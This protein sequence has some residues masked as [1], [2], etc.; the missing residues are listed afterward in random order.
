M[1]HLEGT[2]RY[3]T[4]IMSLDEMVDTEH[5]V[6]II[7][8]FIEVVDLT[9]LGFK[10]TTPA[11][12]GRPSYS[13]AHLAKLYLFGYE[14][15]VR[16]SR[17]LERLCHE[18][19]PALWLLDGLAPDF[20]TIADFRKDNTGALGALFYE[21]A[22]FLDS[23]GLYGKRLAAID[24]TKIKA[25]NSRKS[26][27]T[28][29]KLAKHIA[30][31]TEKMQAYLGELEAADDEETCTRAQ[32]G[33]THCTERL[34][35][36]EG[37]QERLDEV[38]DT[39]L[40][41]V[42]PDARLMVS[43]SGVEMAYNVQAVVDAKHH[44]VADFATTTNPTD[45]GQLAHMAQATQETMRKRDIR[46]VADKGYYSG[47]DLKACEDG[48][49][50]V[51]VARQN[52]PGEASAQKGA[53]SADKFSYDAQTDSYTCPAG[54]LLTCRSKPTS[55]LK[56]Y[57]NKRACKTCPDRSACLSKNS[58]YRYLRR[59]GNTAVLDR[60]A[61]KYADNTADYRL[62][63]QIVEHVFG[64]IKRTMGGGY[65]LVRTQER[66]NAESALL[67][68]CYNMK[69]TK[70]VLG[71]AHMMELLDSYG[72]RFGAHK[73]LCGV[74]AAWTCLISLLNAFHSDNQPYSYRQRDNSP[75]VPTTW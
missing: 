59:D 1:T 49:I 71:F 10:N 64:T 39:Q 16:S 70:A 2:D 43:K 38:E 73:G 65:F 45:H 30:Y 5:I 22:S 75:L 25:S 58:S 23:A 46:F 17:K 33:I 60:A 72:D 32:E 4:R 68:L 34:A 44:L 19:I 63:Q 40:S 51:V 24:G 41:L 7:D 62:R 66:V 26:N 52:K 28:K 3:Q 6:R 11:A 69:R 50:D 56:R 74:C 20:K 37:Y 53:Y 55:K 42:D 21:F 54:N 36:L 12:M 31:H 48:G 29:K 47:A 13:P 67:F 35:V 8:R 57:H 9:E 27:F 61:T 18:S 14:S 15:A